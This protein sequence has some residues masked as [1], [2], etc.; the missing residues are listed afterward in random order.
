MVVRR[1]IAGST[2]LLPTILKK[3]LSGQRC[4]LRP[5]ATAV[6]DRVSSLRLRSLVTSST[7]SAGE[8]MD[9][10]FDTSGVSVDISAAETLNQLC[11]AVMNAGIKVDVLLPFVKKYALLRKKTGASRDLDALRTCRL[12]L[13]RLIRHAPQATLGSF[14]EVLGCVI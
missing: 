1:G 9:V 7:D 11:S 3:S 10:L 6:V 8:P 4:R 2:A 13:K 5:I 14:V 12:V